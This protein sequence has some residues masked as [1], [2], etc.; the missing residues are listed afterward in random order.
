MN[1]D[2]CDELSAQHRLA[3]DQQLQHKENCDCKPNKWGCD[4]FDNHKPHARHIE[5]SKQAVQATIIP[6]QE[7]ITEIN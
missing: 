2:Y 5:E 7:Y 6:V 3:E 4:S 1:K